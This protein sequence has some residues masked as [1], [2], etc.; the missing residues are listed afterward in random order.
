MVVGWLN[1]CQVGRVLTIVYVKWEM[2]PCCNNRLCQNGKCILGSCFL[3]AEV[4]QSSEC[5]KERD[6]FILLSEA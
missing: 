4:V 1:S 6:I 3:L 2:R 5:I